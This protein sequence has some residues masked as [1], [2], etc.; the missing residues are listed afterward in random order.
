MDQERVERIRTSLRRAKLD[1]LVLRLPENIVMG[2]GVWPMNGYSYAVFTADAGP[3][4][5]IAPSCEDEEMGGCWTDD[6]RFFTWPRLDMPDPLT[7]IRDAMG[8]VVR[9][10]RLGRARIGYEGSFESVAPSHNAG[11]P[12]VPCESTNAFLKSLIPSARWTDA[13]A[14]FY[15]LR[16]TKTE[17][18]LARLRVAQRVAG[19]GLKR[20]HESVT[21]G[22]TEAELAA[23]VYQ[24]CLTQGVRLRQARHINV[25]PQVSAGAN[26]CRA[27][28]PVVTTGPRCLRSGEIALL[29]LAVCVDGFWADV[30]RVK[31]AGKPNPLQ[32]DVFAAVS[33]AQR[34]ALAAIRAGVEARVPHDEATRVLVGAGMEKYMVHLTGHGLGFRYHE[35]EPFLMPGNTMKLRVGHVCS[36]EPGLYG[37]NFGGIRLEDNV[38]VTA[39]G[40]ENLTKATKTL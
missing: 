22:R 35:P 36:V 13:T 16:A 2:F 33:A 18:E 20:F 6:V 23:I 21:P 5:L 11:E 30:T 25:Y 7:A 29:E 4:T 27:W 39:A 32:K 31:V 34:A 24:A 3:L 28:R 8:V 17:Q 38:A 15:E 12:I 10:Q 19:F 37:P 40:G 9:R 14:L 26:A 1:A